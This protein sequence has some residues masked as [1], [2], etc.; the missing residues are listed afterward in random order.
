MLDDDNFGA[1]T[2]VECQNIVFGRQIIID[3]SHTV[4]T[5]KWTVN[6]NWMMPQL[7][8]RVVKKK[9][10]ENLYW[11]MLKFYFRITVPK[12]N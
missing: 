7:S 2:S 11:K 1:E 3:D 6:Q 10:H 4:N 8:F 5:G 12:D 9:R